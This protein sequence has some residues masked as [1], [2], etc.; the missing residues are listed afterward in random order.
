MTYE[1]FL[2]SIENNIAHVS[3]NRPDKANA[4]HQKAWEELKEIFELLSDN[5]EARVIVLSGEGQHF[6]AGIDL[7]LLMSLYQLVEHDCEGRKREK[8]RKFIVEAQ[9]TITAIEECKK[10]VIAAVHNG[11]IGGGFDIICACDMRYSTNDAYFSIKEINMGMVADL[12]T[13]QR[14][15]K[16]IPYGIASEMAYTGRKVYGTEAKSLHLVNDTFENKEDMMA[17]VER[18]AMSI[19]E[20]APLAVRGTKHILKY[21]RDHSV[22]DSLDYMAIWNASMLMSKDLMEAFEAKM[23]GREAIY[24]D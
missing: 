2:V 16:I 5:D 15:P 21:S 18:I 23:G 19:A 9:A 14:L 8:L 3:I 11:C 13:L 22:K 24:M 6:C 1:A 10:P 7:N 20:N 4:M 12:G 17:S